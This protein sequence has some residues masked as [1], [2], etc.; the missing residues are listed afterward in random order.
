[1]RELTFGELIHALAGVLVQRLVE[2]GP[3]QLGIRDLQVQF[4]RF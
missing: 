4:D 1:M 3:H 2:H